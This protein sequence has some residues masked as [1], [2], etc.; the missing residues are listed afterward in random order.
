MNT[1][2]A[3]CWRRRRG[4]PPSGRRPRARCSTR[5][6]AVKIR[7]GSFSVEVPGSAVGSQGPSLTVDAKGVHA[8]SNRTDSEITLA[9]RRLLAVRGRGAAPAAACSRGIAARLMQG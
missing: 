4:P 9:R 8:Y 6:P 3:A 7:E 5:L 2:G 1:V